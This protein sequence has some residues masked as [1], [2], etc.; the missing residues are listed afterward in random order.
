MATPPN[1][2]RNCSRSTMS[3]RPIGRGG[4]KSAI[5]LDKISL[6]LN[7]GEIVGLLGRSGCGKSTLIAHRLRA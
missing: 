4:D 1:S 7:E 5:V 6:E 2:E 3:R